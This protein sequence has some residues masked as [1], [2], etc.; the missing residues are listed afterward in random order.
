MH[1]HTYVKLNFLQC[2]T[3]M[4]N[5]FYITLKRALLLKCMHI[6]LVVYIVYNRTANSF[7]TGTHNSLIAYCRLIVREGTI[8]VMCGSLLD[9]TSKDGGK[10]RKIIYT[11]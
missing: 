8:Q 2:S 1:D 4:C 11:V 5:S 3:T 7:Y 10:L 6:M 9:G